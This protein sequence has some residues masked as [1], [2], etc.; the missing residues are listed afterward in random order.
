[1]QTADMAAPLPSNGDAEKAVLAAGLLDSESLLTINEYVAAEEFFFQQ[2]R[3]I[4]LAQMALAA[5]GK[6]VDLVTLVETLQR[7][8]DL[9]KAGGGAY[10]ASIGDGHAKVQNVKHHAAII[11]ENAK[12]RRIV[13]LCH[14]LQGSAMEGADKAGAI[15]ERGA[16]EFLAMM[17]SEGASA[18]PNTWNEAVV[19]AMEEII[20]SIQDHGSVLRGNF[21]IAA[22]D[23]MTSGLRRQDLVLLVGQTSHGKSLLAMQLAVNMDDSGYKGLIFSAE[24]SKEALAK[25]EIAHSANIPLWFLRR[26][27][28]LHHPEKVI[29]DL[30][31]GAAVEGKRKFLVVDRDIKPSRVWSL[32]ELVHRNQGLDFVVVDYDQLVVRAALHGRDDEFKAQARFMAEALAITKRLNILFVL[33]CQPR[34]V[35]DEVARG[36]RSPRIEEIF[37]SSSAANT[38]HHV[39]WVM[40]KYFQT[41][42]DP[43]YERDAKVYILKAR[44]DRAGHVDVGFDPDRVLFVD[45]APSTEK[46]ETVA[47]RKKREKE[48]QGQ[49]EL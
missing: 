49:G 45:A 15:L 8:G 37:G 40:R 38:A 39:L 23:D 5:A 35:D 28:K 33:L 22:L 31:M 19:S 14:A 20:S 26:P 43:A 27:E 25:R 36:K 24:M 41:G 21:G 29:A 18:L 42:M 4:F 11:R 48:E 32:C 1:M 3:T 17:S 2:N 7:N 44:N 13:H 9:E 12:R 34:K 16:Q 47:Q 30:T 10:V 46:K 6:P